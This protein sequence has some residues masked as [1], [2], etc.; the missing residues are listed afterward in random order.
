MEIVSVCF[1][2]AC[3]DLLKQ[4]AGMVKSLQTELQ[5]SQTIHK[6]QSQHLN[7]TKD[8]LAQR[9]F[10]IFTHA[11]TCFSRPETL[12][13]CMLHLS[14]CA[15]ATSF[16]NTCHSRPDHV[17]LTCMK[18]MQICKDRPS[19]IKRKLLPDQLAMLS[20]RSDVSS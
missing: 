5:A 6:E 9:W 1:G 12:R 7:D 19:D 14:R 20:L 18:F 11:Q 2:L 3:A 15:T 10:T 17:Y 8:A 16:S 4:K 13:D